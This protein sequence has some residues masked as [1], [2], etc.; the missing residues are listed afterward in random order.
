ML[1]HN[2]TEAFRNAVTVYCM[3]GESMIKRLFL[4]NDLITQQGGNAISLRTLKK[5]LSTWGNPRP[6]T[7]SHLTPLVNDICDLYVSG[8]KISDILDAVNTWL[9]EAGVVHISKWALYLQLQDWGFNTRCWIG[10]L[11]LSRGR[12]SPSQP[13]AEETSVWRRRSDWP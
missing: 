2:H 9:E 3:S 6:S 4:S 13:W 10:N 8:V 7:T 12:G 5:Q 11:P 1:L